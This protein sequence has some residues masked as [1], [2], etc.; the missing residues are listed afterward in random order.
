MS[1]KKGL[2]YLFYVL[3]LLLLILALKD[4][5]QTIHFF[6]RQQ[7][8]KVELNHLC[9]GVIGIVVAIILAYVFFVFARKWTR[10]IE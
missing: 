8:T 10:K 2:G 3:C 9:I 6:D 4:I 5:M 7:L 1:L